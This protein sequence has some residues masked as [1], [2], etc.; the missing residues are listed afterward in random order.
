MNFGPSG[1]SIQHNERE[2]HTKLTNTR[3]AKL[4]T[5]D[6]NLRYLSALIFLRK[7]TRYLN[8]FIFNMDNNGTPASL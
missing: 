2:Q 7:I 4:N 8:Q 1:C 6:T 5:L 3:I